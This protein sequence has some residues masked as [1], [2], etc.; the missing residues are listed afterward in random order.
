MQIDGW[1]YY[2]HAALPSTAPH[3]A[4]DPTPINDGSIWKLDGA[5]L[6]A[7]W[8]TEFD[9]GYETNW[10]YVIKDTPFDLSMLKA[11]R[12]YE[13]T[14]G[15]KNF[16]VKEINPRECAEDIF[17]VS[18]AAYAEYPKSYRPNLVHDEFVRGVKKIGIS[19]GFTGLILWMMILF[20]DTLVLTSTARNISILP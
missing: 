3:E 15:N 2:N 4:P 14:R 10:W 9:C 7:R 12:R 13:I 8:T 16:Y 1:R 11:K 18:V 5:P 6:L 17:R 20:V 19:I